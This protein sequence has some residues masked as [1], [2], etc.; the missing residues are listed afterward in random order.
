MA[1]MGVTSGVK[2]P[3]T[4]GACTGPTCFSFD[5]VWSSGGLATTLPGCDATTPTCSV[6]KLEAVYYPADGRTY[7]YVDIVNFTNHYYP[8]SYSS[9]VGVFSSPDG[10]TG[11]QYHGIVIPRG[12]AG[13]W[14]GGGIASPGAAV[15]TDGRVLVGYA[16]ENSPSGGIN[17]GI[18]VA[19]ARPIIHSYTYT[20]P[21][22]RT[23]PFMH[24]PIYAN[25]HTCIH[26]PICQYSH[27]H[28]RCGYC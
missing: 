11:W 28:A 16:A 7:A 6:R 20:R 9:E 3:A 19:T 5:A 24:P 10:K 14:D 13:G 17:R 15:T 25:T 2:D 26:P 27:T 18:G 1:E 4:Y 12:P 22:M 23:Q 21:L 8:D